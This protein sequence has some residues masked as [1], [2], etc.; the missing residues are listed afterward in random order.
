MY[1]HYPGIHLSFNNFDVLNTLVPWLAAMIVVADNLID[2]GRQYR[3]I[4]EFLTT[5][6]GIV[7]DA[8]RVSREALK[9]P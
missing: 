8:D 3:D 4:V 9:C 1:C 2:S 7:D 5:Q 6:K